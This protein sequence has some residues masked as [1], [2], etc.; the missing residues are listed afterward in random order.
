[1]PLIDLQTDLKSLKYG[2]DRF[3]GD[4]PAG[5][6]NQP[7]IQKSIPEELSP[8]SPDFLLKE[9]SLERSLTDGSRL[10]SFLRDTKSFQGEAFVIKQELLSRQNP[11]VQGRPNK[12][13][14]GTGIYN[15]LNTIAQVGGVAIGLHTEKQGLLPIFSDRSKYFFDTPES[16]RILFNSR[17]S[18]P[19]FLPT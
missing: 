10:V 6:S 5:S 1:M 14:I 16:L 12:R 15:P 17:L 7:Y 18:L 3:G 8:T 9:G 19:K 4:G 13:K 11:I 2:R